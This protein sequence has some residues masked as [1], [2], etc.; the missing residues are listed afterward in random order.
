MHSGASSGFACPDCGGALFELKERD[1]DR[2][3]CGVGHAYSPE[4]LLSKQSD[5]F[6]NALWIAL[7]AME[8][9]AAL[10]ARLAARSQN[11]N[12]RDT[13]RRFAARAES[14]QNQALR[15]RGW[16]NGR[17]SV[18]ESAGSPAHGEHGRAAPGGRAGSM[19]RPESR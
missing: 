19:E 4:T 12:D 10:C 6:E 15:I 5:S 16:L 3:R 11:R 13:Y 18:E 7:R 9:S 14:A 2:Y 17:F 8:E 1:F